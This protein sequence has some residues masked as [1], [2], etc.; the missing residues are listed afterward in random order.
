M[1]ICPA[2]PSKELL[3]RL[4][5]KA[6]QEPYNSRIKQWLEFCELS[7]DH[8]DSEDVRKGCDFIRRVLRLNGA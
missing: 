2:Q 6:E 4:E 5:E 3:T 1:Y 7:K 8:P